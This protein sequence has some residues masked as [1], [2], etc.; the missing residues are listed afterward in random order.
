[1]SA[2]FQLGR[3]RL[4]EA[5][6]GVRN[7][8]YRYSDL[9]DSSEWSNDHANGCFDEWPLGF[10]TADRPEVT[11]TLIFDG[12]RQVHRGKDLALPENVVTGSVRAISPK[13][14]D[15]AN[16]T[17]IYLDKRVV[18]EQRSTERRRDFA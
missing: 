15:R 17:A 3:L 4:R 7:A 11:A 18:N 1:V 13:G 12:G 6:W 14:R 5:N 10:E 9:V 16:L 8:T 2:L